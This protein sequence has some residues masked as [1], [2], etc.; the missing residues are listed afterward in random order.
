M[1]IDQA[2]IAGGPYQWTS[3]KG[4]LKRLTFNNLSQFDSDRPKAFSVSVEKTLI[5]G[6]EELNDLNDCRFELKEWDKEKFKYAGFWMKKCTDGFGLR[7]TPTESG[8]Y[9]KR[10]CGPGGCGYLADSPLDCIALPNEPDYQ[11]VDKSTMKI[12]TLDKYEM[13]TR[14]VP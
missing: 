1:N 11:F 12:R 9:S 7:F 4:T 6:I 2:I 13:Y 14:C 3:K 8:R 5:T 10:F